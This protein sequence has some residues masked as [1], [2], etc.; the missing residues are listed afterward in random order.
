MRLS[1]G[2]WQ[3]Y[4][5]APQD[6]EIAS[7]QLMVRAGLIQKSSSGLYHSLP[8]GLRSIQKVKQI[9]R[10]EH[11]RAGILELAM[12]VVTPGELWRETGRW[13]KMGQL[14]LKFQDKRGKDLCLSPT[15]EE[16]VV[17]IFR[18]MVKSYKQL[19]LSLY[20]INTKFRDEIRPRY[21][22]MRSREF[23]MKDAYSFVLGQA[24]QEE[25]YQTFSAIYTRIFS[26]M[27]LDFIVVE[28]D[29]GAIGPTQSKNHEFQVIADSGEDDIICCESG[30][31]AANAQRAQTRRDQ[32]AFC[33]SQ[34]AMNKVVTKNHSSIDH[35]CRL[36]QTPHHH[37]LKALLYTAINDGK[38]KHVAIFLLGDDVLNEVKLTNYLKA[39]RIF[40]A[41]S[42][43]LQTLHIPPGYI[44]PVGLEQ[45]QMI[46]DQAIDLNAAYVVGAMEQDH[47][48]QNYIPSRD[49]LKVAN[50]ETTDLR[51]AQAGDICLKT[52]G[53]AM[54]K[55]GIEVGHIFQLGDSYTRAMNALVQDQSGTLVPPLMGCYGIGI[56]RT[57]AACIEQNHDHH[58]IIW[59]KAI[60]PYQVY[61]LAIVKSPE[62]TQLASKLYQQL[63]QAEV[64]TVF[65]DRNLAPGFM[66]KDSDL[67]GLPL[68]VV[69]G[70]RDFKRDGTVE[71]KTRKTGQI[72]KVKP[73][74][75]IHV[76]QA[77]L[78][79]L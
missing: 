53:R 37:A 71:I 73:D 54:V 78:S 79:E 27:G 23:I 3:T 56:T 51:M 29:A 50:L 48:Y 41:S 25:I 59:P 42:E 77:M 46:F 16:P 24:A 10:Q 44:G 74:Q 36:L 28:A 9:V 61:F 17:D 5:E 65:D 72:H 76:V 38:A 1:T 22:L 8:M 66:F 58:G 32:L 60:A 7:H 49:S 39:E 4:K 12:T 33:H 75:L 19:P 2:L 31:Y 64:E 35:V 40:P 57:V 63:S 15:N 43:T 30:G 70:E 20:Q 67:L 68:R 18:K 34:D 55:K 62:L 45:C 47:H 11:D 26:R 21:G 13:E 52:N 6:A 69:L 14:M